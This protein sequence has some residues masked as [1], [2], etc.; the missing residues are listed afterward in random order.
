MPPAGLLAAGDRA[1]VLELPDTHGTPVRLGGV[2]QVPQL[3]VFLP[4]AFTATCSGELRDLDAALHRL[5]AASVVAVTC[6]AGPTLRAWAQHEA[7][8]VTLL[9]DFWPHGRAAEAFGVLDATSGH[10]TRGTF[11]LDDDGVVAWSV[12]QPAGQARSV[13]AYRDAVARLVG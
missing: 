1:P 4:F 5:Q 12:H 2:R 8:T 3:V 9:S 7:V 10:A 6:D 13:T 11:L